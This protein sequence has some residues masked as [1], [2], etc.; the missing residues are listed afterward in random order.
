MQHRTSSGINSQDISDNS[1]YRAF[2]QLFFMFG[3]SFWIALHD[4]QIRPWGR[5]VTH[6]LCFYGL[7]NV[8]CLGDDLGSSQL[9]EGSLGVPRG[10]Y[11]ILD[12][13]FKLLMVREWIWKHPHLEGKGRI[14][15]EVQLF[16]GSLEK[17]HN[18]SCL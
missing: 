2:L 17:G 10:P 6:I 18:G 5:L 8:A 3:V 1:I 11:R 4:R 16:K 14:W 15:C 9:L 13:P 12:G 7:D